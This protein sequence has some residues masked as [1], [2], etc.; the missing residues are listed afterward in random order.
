MKSAQPPVYA[1]LT[2][3]DARL[4]DKARLALLRGIERHRGAPGT[5]KM[6]RSAE[7]AVQENQLLRDAWLAWPA[8]LGP[9][10]AAQLG[11][12]PEKVTSILTA[13]IQR[14]VA[15]LGKPDFGA[16]AATA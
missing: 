5:I 12:D 14:E 6:S 4:F 11:A 16:F 1:D 13:H 2:P 7:L 8:R 9:A 15:Q 3:D 10:I